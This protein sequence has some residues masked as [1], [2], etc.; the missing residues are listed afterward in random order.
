MFNGMKLVSYKNGEK[1]TVVELMKD[2]GDKY[3][4]KVRITEDLS[5]KFARNGPEGDTTVATGLMR[6]LFSS[7]FGAQ[8]SANGTQDMS[9]ETNES[10]ESNKYIFETVDDDYESVN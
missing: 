8:P 10:K 4:N 7:F 6:S 9:T 3:Q 2:M 1:Y 5:I